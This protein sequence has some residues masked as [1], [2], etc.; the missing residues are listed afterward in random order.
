MRCCRVSEFKVALHRVL[1]GLGQ[2]ICS[3]VWVEFSWEEGAEE[4]K[5]L[6]TT[7]PNFLLTRTLL[8]MLN[9][10]LTQPLLLTLFMLLTAI[11]T[12][13]AEPA[14]YTDRT[15]AVTESVKYLHPTT[16]AP[17]NSLY[18]HPNTTIPTPGNAM[19]ARLTPTPAVLA[20]PPTWITTNK[21]AGLAPLPKVHYAYQGK[22]GKSTSP[23]LTLLQH[24]QNK[25]LRLAVVSS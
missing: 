3:E 9:L 21:L 12:T 20:A 18:P 19:D 6:K 24:V 25:R 13:A 4:L 22:V 23:G 7:D 10:P 11:Y 16:N 14:E 8:V 1:L 2:V 5:V 17:H 15:S